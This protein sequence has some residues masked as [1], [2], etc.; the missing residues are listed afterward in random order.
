MKLFDKTVLQPL[1]ETV[2]MAA[3]PFNKVRWGVNE[4]EGKWDAAVRA[5]YAIQ[6]AAAVGE[7]QRIATEAL[8][9]MARTGVTKT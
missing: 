1:E 6:R 3:N 9:T 2:T 5:F 7:A 4:I 8:K